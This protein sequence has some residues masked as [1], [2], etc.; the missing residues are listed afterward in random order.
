MR[1]EEVRFWFYFQSECL[2]L[3][4]IYYLLEENSML[5]QKILKKLYVTLLPFN[6]KSFFIGLTA[7]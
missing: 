2:L 5:H 7:K 6:L 1:S 3:L 4:F